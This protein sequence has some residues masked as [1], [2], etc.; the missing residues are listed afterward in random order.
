VRALAEFAHGWLDLVLV[1]YATIG[2]LARQ[3]G[4]G[5]AKTLATRLSCYPD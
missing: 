1:S 5:K 3:D 4:Q 2:P